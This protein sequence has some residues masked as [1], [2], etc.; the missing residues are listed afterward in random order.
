[1]KILGIDPGKTGA[2]ALFDPTRTAK[3][4]LRWIVHDIAPTTGE[5][6]DWL[7]RFA[8]DHAFL[9]YVTPMMGWGTVPSFRL[10]ES[11]GK[12]QATLE[13]CD[14]PTIR[15][16]PSAWKRHHGLI[17]QD[18]D[19][20]RRLAINTFPELAELLR[21]KMD[22]GRADAVLIAAYGASRLGELF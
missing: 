21:R 3:S 18:K 7:R 2:L 19:S 17:K 8:P 11:S 9:E 13:C 12:I 22:H 5:L 10:G 14:V 1:M 15:V 20:G 6:R 16:V 4:G